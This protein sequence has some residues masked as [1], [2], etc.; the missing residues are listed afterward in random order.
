VKLCSNLLHNSKIESEETKPFERLWISS[1]KD[2]TIKEG[3]EK[4]SWES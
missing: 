1:M 3:F 4:L 2:A